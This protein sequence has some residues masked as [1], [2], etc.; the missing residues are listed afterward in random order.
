MKKLHRF[1]ISEI[2]TKNKLE[3]QDK[4]TVHLITNV[5]KLKVGEECI[6]FSE[7]SDDY[8]CKIDEVTKRSVFLNV[9][10]ENKKILIPKNVT[11]CVSII[12]RD[13]FEL[14]VQKLTELGISKI[15]PIISDR[16][17]KQSLRID[18]LQ[19][20]S[21]E[22]L[23]QSGRSDRVKISSPASLEEAL[24]RNKDTE[25][26][27]FDIEG[28]SFQ[29]CVRQDLTQ[30]IFYIGPEGGWSDKDKELFKKYN[31]KSCS[32]GGTVLRAE[33]ASIVACDRLIWR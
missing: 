17:V 7:G 20:I 26:I 29:S 23:E 6:V 19:K 16:T 32:L 21:N 24:E 11:A 1:L 5:L 14:V 22:A 10:G 27:Y 30:D 15:I 8:I 33:T 12:K 13:N 28:Q 9:V 2:P 4:E 18:R 31:V 25:S 3:I